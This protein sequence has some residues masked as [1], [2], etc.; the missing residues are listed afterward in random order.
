MKLIVNQAYD[1]M[2]LHGTQTL[3]QILDGIN[4]QHARRARLR[5]PGAR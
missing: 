3:G 5:P 4:A 1:N 2:G